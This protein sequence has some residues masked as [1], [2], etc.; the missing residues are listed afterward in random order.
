MRWNIVQALG[1]WRR[2]RRRRPLCCRNNTALAAARGWVHSCRRQG[3]EEIFGLFR[4]EKLTR[5]Q[6]VQYQ[7]YK[8][9][10]ANL[11]PT[12][13]PRSPSCHPRVRRFG[14]FVLRRDGISREVLE[15]LL[16]IIPPRS[17]PRNI[18]LW[19]LI[20]FPRGRIF[21]QMRRIKVFM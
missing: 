4:D 14:S 21:S 13:H 7:V 9:T 8:C 2:R 5:Q 18:C 11:V 1:P 6:A 20:A 12:W 16:A 17:L 10:S 3:V 15:V 19:S